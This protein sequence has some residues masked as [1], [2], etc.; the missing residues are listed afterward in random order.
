MELYTKDA[1]KFLREREAF[2]WRDN[3]EK[4]S[5]LL[6]HL[7]QCRRLV[8]IGCGWG[9]FLQ[10]AQDR[11]SEVWGVDESS[12]GLQDIASVCPK[13][14][15]VTCRADRLDLPDDYF[16]VAVT[17]QMLHEV[18]LF[19]AESETQTVLGEIRRIL[20]SGGKYLLLDHLDAGEGEVTVK[21]PPAKIEQLDEFERKLQCYRATHRNMGDGIIRILKRPLQDFLTKYWSLN[22]PMESIEMKETHN[23]FEKTET[24]RLVESSGLVVRRWI[25]FSDIRKDLTRVGGILLQGDSWFRK[26]LLIATKP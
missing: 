8:D 17:S 25:P 26:F 6:E 9:K 23:V 18:K 24:A 2:W 13:A 7:D 19:G 3:Q 5:L 20:T 10:L 11:V 12:H 22:S 14:H 1:V 4:F 15:V 16:D 21:L